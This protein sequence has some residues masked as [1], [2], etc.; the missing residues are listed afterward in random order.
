[1]NSKNNQK[2]E[3]VLSSELLDDYVYDETV[4]ESY[5]YLFK[6]HGRNG[7]VVY[8]MV[9]YIMLDSLVEETGCLLDDK[10]REYITELCVTAYLSDNSDM[11]DLSYLAYMVGMQV[12]NGTYT[13]ESLKNMSPNVLAQFALCISTAKLERSESYSLL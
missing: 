4:H 11:L 6:K 5:E 3:R 12:I 8:K 9:C 2:I 10:L 1:M 13:V 7:I